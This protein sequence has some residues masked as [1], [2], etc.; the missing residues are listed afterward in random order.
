MKICGKRHLACLMLL[1]LLSGC[2]NNSAPSQTGGPPPAQEEPAAEPTRPALPGAVF[3]SIENH[4]QARPQSGLDKA[5]LVFEMDSEAGITRFLALYYS[6]AADQIGPIRSARSYFVQ[7]TKAFDSPFAHAGGS[8][9]ALSLLKT[10]KIK[11]LDEIYGSGAYFWRS[12]DRKMPH[13]LYTSTELLVRGA[14]QKGYRLLP[15]TPLP[16]GAA[17][18]DVEA[19]SLSLNYAD[20]KYYKYITEYRYDGGVYAKF[21]NG[22][23]FRDIGGSQIAAANVIVLIARTKW[24]GNQDPPLTDIKIVGE[25]PAFYFTQRKIY[26]GEWK[27]TAPETHFQFTA[28]GEPMLFSPG[29]TWINVIPAKTAL[30]YTTAAD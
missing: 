25:G 29:K 19:V 11:N 3:A 7:I 6:E 18:G 9:E 23:P 8:E 13:N 12:K 16:E 4:P 2:R 24:L 5:D 20:N 14:N 27:K 22:E 30:S 26:K 28:A 10:L 15:Y 1:L 17:E 21:V